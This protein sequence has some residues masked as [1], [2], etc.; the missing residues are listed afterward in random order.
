MPRL[1]PS[2]KPKGS[3]CVKLLILG[4]CHGH[5]DLVSEACQAAE[6]AHDV[7]AAIQV[8][9]F[10]LFP[11][12]LNLLV[13]GEIAPLPIPVHVI[14]GN[15]EDHSWLF[16]SRTNGHRTA[17]ANANLHFHPRGTT[18]EIGG[19]RVGFIGGALHADRRQE[20]AGM[21]Q[22]LSAGSSARR[23]PADPAWANWVTEGDS[24][25]ALSAFTAD[26]PHLMVSH[27]CPGG[28]GIGMAGA[29]HLVED[30][31]RFITRPGF[32]SGPF[33]DCGEGSLTRL[34][35]QLPHKPDQWVFGHFHAVHDRTIDH[36]RFVCVGSTDD[37][38]GV[39]GVRPVIYDTRLR[40]LWMDP[41][42]RL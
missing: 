32:S 29:L 40:T 31:D 25:R 6:L 18:M 33:H 28:I 10:G 35:R 21:W 42:S 9:D 8:G 39:T 15:H 3:T 41:A 13:S 14:D 37:S 4:D 16:E 22:P 30:A 1:A 17:W 12:L 38:D 19:A 7:D 36:T 5:Y 20:W 23:I 34:W 2:V 24:E 11:K 26:P 27:S